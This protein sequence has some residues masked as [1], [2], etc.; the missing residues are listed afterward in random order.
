M[1]SA[2]TVRRPFKRDS[3]DRAAQ[4]HVRFLSFSPQQE[5]VVAGAADSHHL[6]QLVHC[7]LRFGCFA[8][9]LVEPVV[10]LPTTGGTC[11][12]K[13][14][15]TFFKKSIS[16][17]CCPI[18]RSSSGIRCSSSFPWVCAACPGNARCSPR[19]RYFR[20]ALPG[21]QLAH[22]SNL[23]LA[24]ILLSGHKH[25]SPPFNVTCPLISCLTFGVHSSESSPCF[26]LSMPLSEREL[27]K[28]RSQL[29][30]EL[31]TSSFAQ[32]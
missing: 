4:V 13:R 3:L 10:P 12:L 26:S 15:K 16:I 23:Q 30:N 28:R 11:S 2:I 29:R 27:V 19:A 6:A 8:D 17:A 9:L 32:A 14:R 7:D 1:Y 22:G 21:V 24:G 31:P 5:T 18:L 25:C 20:Y